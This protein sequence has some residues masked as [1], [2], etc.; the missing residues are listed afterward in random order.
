MKNTH[1]VPNSLK[2]LMLEIHNIINIPFILYG[3]VPTDIL[4]CKKFPIKE[5]DIAIIGSDH[6]ITTVRN[7]ISKRGFRIIEAQRP[8]YIHKDKKVVLLYA[9]NNR[10]FLDIA[11]LDSPNL[12]GHFNVETFY[13]RYPQLDCIDNFDTLEAIK[14]R[15]IKLIRPIDTENPYLLMGRFLRL[16]AKYSIDLKTTEHNRLLENITK[17]IKTFNFTTHFHRIA[18]ISCISSL[19]KAILLAKKRNV[20]VRELIDLGTIKVLLPEVFKSIENSK[21]QF[22]SALKET[23]TK[24]QIV[25]TILSFLNDRN[26][27]IFKERIK[28]FETR[29]WNKEDLN[30]VELV[31][32]K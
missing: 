6:K 25:Y 19:F 13:C 4:L 9:Q 15:S 24:T 32:K 30:C 31:A 28:M 14:K 23:R 16:C 8:Y 26:K 17:Q 10:W 18:N 20:F 7:Q 22:I 2:H 1:P 29:R 3:G 27:E 5:L 21:S 11:F 12:L